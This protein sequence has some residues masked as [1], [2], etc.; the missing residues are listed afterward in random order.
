MLAF[1][2]DYAIRSNHVAGERLTKTGDAAF[3][4]RDWPRRF[5]SNETSNLTAVVYYA[6]QIKCKFYLAG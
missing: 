6:C 2:G 3:S 1:T 4:F 5:V